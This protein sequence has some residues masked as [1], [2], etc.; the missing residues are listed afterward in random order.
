LTFLDWD[1]DGADELL[2]GSD[3]F[4]IRVFKHEEMIFDIN[5]ASKVILL[6][7]ISR[8]IFGY[9]LAS[10]GYGVYHKSKRLWR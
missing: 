10:G 5:E 2:A 1:E 7:R 8:S 6:T 3:D 9:S 4:S